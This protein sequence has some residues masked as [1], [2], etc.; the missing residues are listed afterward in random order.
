ELVRGPVDDVF[1]RNPVVAGTQ[2]RTGPGSRAALRLSG[3]ESLR[4]DTGTEV[5]LVSAHLL[6]LERGAIY[7][8]SGGRHALP[9]EVQTRFGTVRDIGT[10]F[11]VRAEDALGVAVREGSVGVSTPREH[12]HVAAG[13]AA[14]VSAAGSHDVRSLDGTGGAWTTS[15]APPFAI[16]GRTVAELLDWCAR[17]TGV[18]IRY[19]DRE[20]EQIAGSTRLHG[21][22][23]DTRPDDAAELILPTAGLGA[24]RRGG[25]L[26]VVRHPPPR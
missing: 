22:P 13:Y 3:G 11:E 23:V 4:L 17:E 24:V 5:R 20:V 7:I 18:A 14:T 16:E 2:L 19:A 21:A 25:T 9:V 6:E 1:G 15:I 10:R 12:F 26:V 8:D